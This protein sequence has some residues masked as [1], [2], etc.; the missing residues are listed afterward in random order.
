MRSLSSQNEIISGPSLLVDKILELTRSENI[1][2][3]VNHKLKG[4]LIFIDDTP[5]TVATT[6]GDKSAKLYLRSVGDNL[7]SPL[8]TEVCQ[9]SPRVGLEL[10][11][12]SISPTAK[13]PYVSFVGKMYRYF[14]Q[15]DVL[16]S[17][18]RY[19]NI[20]WYLS[21]RDFIN[22]LGEGTLTERT[23]EL[24]ARLG[25]ET[26]IRR[27]HLEKYI[28]AFRNGHQKQDLRNFVG[29]IGKGTSSNPIKFLTMIG[30]LCRLGLLDE[31]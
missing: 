19:Y 11:H 3:L 22:S 8:T 15:P 10:S 13:D 18:L 27:M 14:I 25:K 20:I 16:K 1:A 2:E 9:C 5:G 4:H 31:P 7:N 30:V 24:L 29:S 26:C 23:T 6:S 21:R 12:P 17:S 28:T